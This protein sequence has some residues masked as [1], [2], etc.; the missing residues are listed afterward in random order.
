MAVAGSGAALY[1]E[2]GIVQLE[3]AAERVGLIPDAEQSEEDVIVWKE[4]GG[5]VMRS[6]ALAPPA[7]RV[8]RRLPGVSEY[9]EVEA[10]AQAREGGEAEEWEVKYGRDPRGRYEVRVGAEVV[11]VERQGYKEAWGEWV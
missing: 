2:R 4:A 3:R 9:E 1:A 5:A 7:M 11:M 10:W 6:A 8:L